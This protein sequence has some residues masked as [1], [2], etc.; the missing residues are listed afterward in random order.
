M[1]FGANY[2]TRCTETFETTQTGRDKA[3]QATQSYKIVVDNILGR[4]D[5][6]GL[7]IVGFLNALVRGVAW[8]AQR[9]VLYR[10]DVLRSR[11]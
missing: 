6:I 5:V 3:I 10:D 11:T 9:G 2:D 4:V 7:I 8:L 1:R